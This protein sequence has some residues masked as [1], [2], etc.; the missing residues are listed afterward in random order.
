[1]DIPAFMI[2]EKSDHSGYFLIYHRLLSCEVHDRNY[3]SFIVFHLLCKYC[4]YD[5]S[6]SCNKLMT[7]FSLTPH[8]PTDVFDISDVSFF[9]LLVPTSEDI[10][11][12]GAMDLVLAGVLS[13]VYCLQKWLKKP[14][15]CL[16]KKIGMT[17]VGI[18]GFL[19]SAANNMAMFATFDKMKENE[20]ILNV[21][22]ANL[23]SICNWWLSCFY[24]C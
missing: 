8:V 22:F 5:W 14:L 20:H 7:W 21:A 24:S 10:V 18:T 15:A 13:F 1:M 9:W 2:F 3:K 12:A 19:Y 17:K 6:G 16:G 4:S 23:R 11:V